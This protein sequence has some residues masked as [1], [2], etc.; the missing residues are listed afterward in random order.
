[1]R[2]TRT[3]RQDNKIGKRSYSRIAASMVVGS[4]V[5]VGAASGVAVMAA[6]AASTP[7]AIV[8]GAVKSVSPHS[9]VVDGAVNP[10]G[11][12]TDWYVEYGPNTTFD[13][14]T[15]VVSA[16]SGVATIDVDKTIPGLS[17]ATSYDYRFVAKN[18]AGTTFGTSGS[19]NT[20]AA[21]SVITGAASGIGA[22]T[23]TLSGSVDPQ[24]LGTNWYFEYG[25]TTHFGSKTAEHHLVPS[26]NRVNVTAAI[27]GLKPQD[28]Y[29]FRLVALNAA[30]TSV[31]ADLTF[32]T[33]LPVTLSTSSSDVV[34]GSSTVLSGAVAS[35]TVG[36]NVTIE[37]EQ[38][39]QGA[40]AVIATVVSGTGGAW[41]YSASPSVRTTYEAVAGGG[42]SS[43]VV[44][45]V[46]PAVGLTS[47]S[48]GRLLTQVV[49]AISFSSHVLQLQIL[50]DGIWATWKHV[51]L[52]AN[53][54]STFVTRLPNGVKT[55]RM[56]IAPFVA[57]ID[58]AA[59]GYLAGYSRA[60]RK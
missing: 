1:M 34:Y 27:A 57:G 28:T 41:N 59:P 49:A 33:G 45:G 25:T 11:A 9:A 43:P 3:T 46:S 32:Q 10:H 8:T 18:A 56:A 15:A 58:Q 47:L 51:R 37:G 26:P 17:P 21:P 38:F 48:R 2:R 54:E 6:S 24:A 16:G 22:S 36:E 44:V 4:L 14:T 60:I 29:H 5:S 19:F 40:F 13:A 30:G 35:G 31:G 55:V 52:N 42:T 23:A 20:S 53:G 39:N 50:S 7:P 12:T